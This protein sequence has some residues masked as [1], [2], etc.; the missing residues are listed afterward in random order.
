MDL[1]LIILF[2]SNFQVSFLLTYLVFDI[3][4]NEKAEDYCADCDISLCSQCLKDH[5]ENHELI[6][7]KL[8]SICK[9]QNKNCTSKPIKYYCQSC[10]KYF[11]GESNCIY[12]HSGENHN[13]IELSSFYKNER[14]EEFQR[15]LNE[16]KDNFSNNFYLIKRTLQQLKDLLIYWEDEF[17]KIKE[18]I[19]Q[20]LKFY[21]GLYET[22]SNTCKFQNINSMK[23]LWTNFFYEKKDFNSPTFQALA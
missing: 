15:R 2:H 10:R 11:C 19:K 6:S 21:E 18:N 17:R 7:S 20:K 13:T 16:N 12:E 22:Y 4:K 23:N 14:G 9:C 1:V 5:N 8:R 3:H